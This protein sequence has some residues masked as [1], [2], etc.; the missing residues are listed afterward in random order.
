M[1]AWRI[2]ACSTVAL[3]AAACSTAQ[4]TEHGPPGSGHWP[5]R[6]L[7]ASNPQLRTRLEL[8]A[9]RIVAGSPIEGTLVVT[10]SSSTA[11]NLTRE[12]RPQYEVTLTNSRFPPAYA[13]LTSCTDAP[14][15]IHPGVTR[16]PITVRTTYLSCTNTPTSGADSS[17]PK[18]TATG[19]PAMPDGTYEAILV[20][21]QL[22]LPAPK[23]VV[24]TLVAG[25]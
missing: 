12:C 11:I 25:G 23:P 21:D 13:F 10:N 24:V 4:T 16:L 1:R 8:S 20:G 3:I 7:L 14:F 6:G 17:F 18:C 2:V 15:V 9:T 22:P 19:D 5:S